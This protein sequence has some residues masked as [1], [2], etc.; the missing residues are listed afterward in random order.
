MAGAVTVK[1]VPRTPTT[2]V[3]VCT[4]M[5][6]LPVSFATLHRHGARHQVEGRPLLGADLPDF[7]ENCVRGDTEWWTKA[8]RRGS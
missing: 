6:W 7:H 2:V 1:S 4:C 5:A 3:S 8:P